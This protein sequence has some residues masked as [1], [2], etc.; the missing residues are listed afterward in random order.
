MKQLRPY[1]S[2]AI[3][4]SLSRLRDGV[5]SQIISLPTGAGKTFTAAKLVEMGGFKNV[6]FCVDNEE[7]AEQAA[8]AFLRE[9]CDSEYCDKIQST[10]FINYIRKNDINSGYKV[11][12][13]KADVFEPDGN[14]VVASLQTLHRR[15]DKLSP[16][17]YDCVIVDECHISS[18]NSYQ[19]GILHF[20]PKLRLGLSATPIRTDGMQLGDIFDEIVYNYTLFDAI[21]DGYLVELDAIKIKTNVSLDSVKTLGGDLNEKQLSNEVNTLAR[22]NLIAESYLKYCKGMKTIGFAV[23]IRHAMDLA[24]TFVQ[25]GIKASAISSNE[26]LTGDRSQNVRDFKAGKI[27]VLFNVNILT[28]GFDNPP[29]SCIIMARPTKSLTLY[30]QAVGRATRSLPGVIDGLETDIERVAAIQASHKPKAII[31]DIVDNTSKHNLINAWELDRTLPPEE[32]TFI[33]Q[34]KRDKLIEARRMSQL[35]HTREK[36]EIVKLLAVPKVVVNKSI[37]MLEPATS[38][39]LLWIADLGY[40][41]QNQHYTKKMC[42]EIILALPAT[43]KQIQLVRRLNYDIS[44][45]VLTRGDI[46]AIMLDV[47][48]R[49]DKPKPF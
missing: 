48:K 7:L 40:D 3:E 1:Q 2:E 5:T 38:A 43:E 15:L 26:E 4:A 29:V 44:G 41:I 24:D 12:L 9:S 31:L 46:Q 10:G 19:K 39:Q 18:A 13:I 36:D 35:T 14:F 33:T 21:K 20:A 17:Q 42:N 47:E 23:D 45:R 16:T 8:M 6:L 22:N 49:K 30:L 11:G 32:R 27:D 25:Y 37:K 28:K 34:E